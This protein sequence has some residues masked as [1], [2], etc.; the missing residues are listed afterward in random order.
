[1]REDIEFLIELQEVD[2]KLFEIK[3]SRGDLPEWVRRI[4]NEK[5]EMEENIKKKKNQVTENNKIK[6]KL[7]LDVGGFQVKLK[8]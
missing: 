3:M 5:N 8:K 2:N 1:M 6:K 4:T 7:D